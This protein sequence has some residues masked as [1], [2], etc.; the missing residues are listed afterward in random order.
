LLFKLGRLEEARV[1]FER[2]AS[3]T[4]NSRERELLA[5]R[6]AACVRGLTPS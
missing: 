1:E 6:A 4:R 3:L 2:A 5:A